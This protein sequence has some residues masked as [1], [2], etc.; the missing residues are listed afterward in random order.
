MIAGDRVRVQVRL[1]VAPERAFEAF[2]AEI[3]QWWRRGMAYRV[4][5]RNPGRLR[6]EPGVGGRLVETYEAGGAALE[7]VT[8]EILAWEPPSRLVFAWRSVTFVDGE[9][10]TVEVR[11]EPDRDATVVTLTHT[12]F[13][14]LRA[15]HPVRHS[16]E[17]AAFIGRFGLWWGALLRGL[18]EHV[19]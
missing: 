7:A 16:E 5:G 4:S 9:S 8:G 3:D 11:F 12:G 10:T 6:L 1:S 19:A 15:D 2:T 17:V 14:S 18:R 13:A